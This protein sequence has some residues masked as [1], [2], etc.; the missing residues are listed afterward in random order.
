MI[1]LPV[2]RHDVYG[3][4]WIQTLVPPRRQS[5]PAVSRVARYTVKTYGRPT[6]TSCSRSRPPPVQLRGSPSV[7]STCS[8]NAS[9]SSLLPFSTPTRKRRSG[10]FVPNTAPV[11]VAYWTVP[12]RRAGTVRAGRGSRRGSGA[13]DVD[14]VVEVCLVVDGSVVTS[15]IGA[16]GQG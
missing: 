14:G 12:Q 11:R 1:A 8:A 15:T 7:A 10:P 16:G 2:V 3:R 6:A 9:T 13:A 4:P 5:S